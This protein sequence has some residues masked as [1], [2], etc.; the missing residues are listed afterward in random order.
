VRDSVYHGRHLA[1]SSFLGKF[2]AFV[3]SRT[4]RAL[5]LYFNRM[6]VWFANIC[7]TVFEMLQSKRASIIAMDFAKPE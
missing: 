5:L 7:V 1:R 2:L 3:L 4:I 6:A